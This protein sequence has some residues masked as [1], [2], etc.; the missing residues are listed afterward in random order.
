MRSEELT[1]NKIEI[2]TNQIREFLFE[3]NARYGNSALEPLGVFTKHLSVENITRSGILVRLDDKLKRIQNS[4][5][6]RKND[7]VDLV[8][9]CILLMVCE[10]W[11]DLQDQI[12]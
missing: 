12:D 10:E 1:Q 7:V 6:L 5:I 11:T 4:S 3:K 9:Y 2:I 8:G